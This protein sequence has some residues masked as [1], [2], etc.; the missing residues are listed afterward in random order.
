MAV[1]AFF[2]IVCAPMVVQAQT[3]QVSKPVNFREGAGKEHP[4][5]RVL[6]QDEKVEKIG[7]EAGYTKIR[8]GKGETGYV[9][10]AYLTRITDT[11]IRVPAFDEF[12]ADLERGGVRAQTF[13]GPQRYF[14]ESILEFLRIENRPMYVILLPLLVAIL[15]GVMGGVLLKAGYPK[16]EM[17]VPA[18]LGVARSRALK[19]AIMIAGSYL[20]AEALVY[21]LDL[22]LY[23][24]AREENT[25]LVMILAAPRMALAGPIAV[26]DALAGNWVVGIAVV[27]FLAMTAWP[28]F[29]SRD[30]APAAR[31]DGD[32]FPS[33]TPLDGQGGASF[34]TEDGKPGTD[35]V[36]DADT[37]ISA[38]SATDPGADESDQD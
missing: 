24:A 12:T 28:G 6:E 18:G 26:I 8:T 15:V 7:S 33:Y 14:F 22:S 31:S 4:V 10:G 2:I 21:F 27:L 29:D 17:V 25:M 13:P 20:V 37:R 32:T 34:E 23:Y 11:G 9:W 35:E 38:E 1:L 19:V 30:P 36:I 16:I 3:Y 5:I